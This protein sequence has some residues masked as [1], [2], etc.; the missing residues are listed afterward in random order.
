[1][2]TLHTALRCLKH[3]ATLLSIALLLAN[4]HW[5]KTSSPSWWTGKLSDFAGL[6]FLPFL[7]ASFLG[8]LLDRKNISPNA[9]GR[10]AFGFTAVWFAAFKALPIANAATCALLAAL[11][12][13]PVQLVLDRTDL[14]ALTALVPAWL[15]WTRQVRVRQNEPSK[16]AW[17]A[18]AFGVLATAATSPPPPIPVFQRLYEEGGRLYAYDA[19]GYYSLTGAGG[20]LAISKDGGR[21][22]TAFSSRDLGPTSSR[23]RAVQ[24]CDPENAQLCFRI[25]PA[26]VESSLDGGET[27][28]VAWSV[29]NGRRLFM[30]R[31][32]RGGGLL[33]SKSI[34]IGPYDLIFTPPVGPNR[35]STVVFAMGNEGVLLRTSEGIWERI[36]ILN[37]RPTAFSAK[38]AFDALWIIS[39]ETDVVAFLVLLTIS[40]LSYRAASTLKRLGSSPISVDWAVQPLVLMDFLFVIGWGLWALGGLYWTG[41]FTIGGLPFVW[42]LSELSRPILIVP[43]VFIIVPYIGIIW[44]WKRI[45]K[46]PLKPDA[47]VGAFWRTV[48]IAVGLALGTFGPFVLWT[49]GVIPLY[50]LAVALA[51]VLALVVFAIGIKSVP[52]R[53]SPTEIH[54]A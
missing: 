51:I 6:F 11:L 15:L 25:G 13:H 34:D 18:L 27:F 33:L 28:Q 50:E 16:R 40:F 39:V 52:G 7:I 35:L 37:A 54:S 17:L 23:E 41:A 49:V 26:Q 42:A 38:D 12:G 8:L 29:P 4:D 30:E 31:E 10:L 47:A 22:W 1:M 46:L 9:L 20:P 53:F 21:T 14:I 3:P 24:A 19:H 45:A 36:A 43:M 5:L 44:A 2:S 48:V 32:T